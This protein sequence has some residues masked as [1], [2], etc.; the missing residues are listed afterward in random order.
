[1][2]T[3]LLVLGG[4]KPKTA[5]SAP[6]TTILENK[7]KQAKKQQFTLHNGVLADTNAKLAYHYS[8]SSHSSHSSHYSH[9]SSRY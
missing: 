9:Y 6:I 2:I 7:D 3:C 4:I 5:S 8:H 1:M